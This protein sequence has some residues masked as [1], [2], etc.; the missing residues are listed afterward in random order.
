MNGRRL[1]PC[2]GTLVLMGCSIGRSAMP[3]PGSPGPVGARPLPPLRDSINQGMAPNRGLPRPASPGVAAPAAPA[4]EAPPPI[5]VEPAPA[6]AAAPVDPAIRPA[7]NVGPPGGPAATAPGSPGGPKGAE[8]RSE[9]DS[10]TPVGMTVATVGGTPISRL[11]LQEAVQEWQ[12]TN[13]P[14]G[15]R[16]GPDEI[17]AL[18]EVMLE[19]LIDR[20]LYAQEAR[21]ALLK[22]DKQ[23]QMFEEFANGA[24]KEREIPRLCRKY[25]VP[26]EIDLRKRLEQQ[27]RSLELLRQDFLEDTLAREFVSKRVRERVGEPGQPE[28]VAY[29]RAHT[30]EFDRPAQVTW[31]EIVVKVEPGGDR[32]AARRKAEGILRRLASGGDFAAIAKAE[33]QG[34]TAA[35]GGLWQTEPGASAVPAVNAALDTLPV[36]S[37]SPILEGPSSLH[38]VRIEGRRA[39]GPLPFDDDEGVVQR[40]IREKLTVE[41]FQK[42]L[43]QYN[44]HLRSRT[45]ITYLIPPRPEAGGP[46]RDP[47]AVRTGAAGR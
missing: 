18:S 26:H 14:K 13:V 35:K 33:S 29:Y 22:S 28:L 7:S 8:I 4:N 23:R 1:A 16:L 15:Q 2:L 19:Q 12:R 20:E 31:R 45:L 11:D 32:L 46:T 42:E 37:I 47:K 10:G 43:K 36:N 6:P 41:C 38:L 40:T 9:V 3:D 27:G 34:P 44:Q 5:L 17:N 24:W 30:E 39:A 21:R 25:K